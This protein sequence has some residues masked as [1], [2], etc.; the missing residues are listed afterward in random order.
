MG[1]MRLRE[2]PELD[3]PVEEAAI[4]SRMLRLHLD[5]F[6][7]SA[8]DLARLLHVYERQLNEFYDLS[9]KPT[10]QGMRLRLVR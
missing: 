10:V 2:P 8:N 9:A 1:K 5:T 4:I 6:G 7:Y 3:F